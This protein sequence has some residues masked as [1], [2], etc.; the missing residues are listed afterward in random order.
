M[1][2]FVRARIA[3]LSTS[4][5]LLSLMT[6]GLLFK[7]DANLWL[8]E[9]TSDAGF[10]LSDIFISGLERT[11]QSDVE[12]VLDVDSGMPVL[13]IDL[14]EIQSKIEALPWVKH[15]EINRTLPGSLHIS[16][17]ERQ[18]FALAQLN[19]Q[20]NLIDPEGIA[21]TDRGLAA[22]K[23][24]ILIVGAFAPSDLKQFKQMILAH[25]TLAQQVRSAVWVNNRRW[26][27]IFENGIRVKLPSFGA[28][29][30]DARGAWDRL[31]DLNNRFNILEREVSV[32]DLRLPDR[33]V[34]R[35][36]PTGRLKMAGDEWA[37]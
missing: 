36:T 15:A 12:A 3:L 27:L 6:A 19:G 28:D 37:L 9:T 2:H 31:T 25:E 21:I 5:A 33:L 34:V 24:L 35:V 32:I 20:V 22:Y 4:F 11:K 18:P 14:A 8:M 23:D 1:T 29:N 30:F 17:V 10:V 13:A 26:D 7:N 16:I